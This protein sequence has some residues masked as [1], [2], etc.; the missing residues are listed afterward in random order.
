MLKLPEIVSRVHR[1]AGTYNAD[2]LPVVFIGP[3]GARLRMGTSKVA[4]NGEHGVELC[5]ELERE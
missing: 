2:S 3:E 1:A 4:M 5:I